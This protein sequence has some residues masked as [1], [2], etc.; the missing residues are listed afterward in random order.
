[1][2]K[3]G[4]RKVIK[5]KT[6]KKNT[7][8]AW[9]DRDHLGYTHLPIEHYGGGMTRGNDDDDNNVLTQQQEDSQFFLKVKPGATPHFKL[10]DC[11]L[12]IIMLFLFFVCV[13]GFIVK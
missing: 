10:S 9:R 11:K 6:E 3:K 12:Y 5:K 2:Q 8:R 13:S 7:K 4:K 1:M